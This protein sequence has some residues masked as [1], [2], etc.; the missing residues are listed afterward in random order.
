MECSRLPAMKPEIIFKYPLNNTKNLEINNLIASICFPNGIKVCYNE[1][2]PYIIEDYTTSI[3]NQKSERYYMMNYHFY[4]QIPNDIYLKEYEMTSL[5]YYLKQY[6]DRFIELSENELNDEII[7]S[8]QKVFEISQDL[9]LR[10]KVYVPFCICLISKYPY[11]QEMKNCLQSIYT[12][13]KK[14]KKY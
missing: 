2:N 6:G 10:D 7:N 1:N 14:E 3:I 13:I 4:L 8:I 5:K 11:V 9:G 12:I